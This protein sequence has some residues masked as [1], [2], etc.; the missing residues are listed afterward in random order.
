[1]YLGSAWFEEWPGD[2]V[3]DAGTAWFGGPDISCAEF[4]FDGGDCASD[5]SGTPAVPPE[6][7]ADCIS[8]GEAGHYDCELE[9]FK[10]VHFGSTWLEEWPGDGVCDDGTGW[11]GGPDISCAEF[12]FDGGDCAVC[13][14]SDEGAADSTG[15]ACTDYIDD[16]DRCGL[17]DDEDFDSA[18]VCC[19]CG[20]GT[21]G[22]SDGSDAGEPSDTGAVGED[23]T[24]IVDDGDADADDGETGPVPG[25]ACETGGYVYDCAGVCIS[26]G[27]AETWPGDGMCDGESAF[28]GAHLDCEAFEFDG[29]DCGTGSGGDGD[30]GVPGASCGEDMV[31]DCDMT[32]VSEPAAL[33]SI[34]DGWCDAGGWWSSYDLYCSAFSFDGSDCMIP[35]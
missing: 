3:C 35:F 4:D 19:A 6:I 23:D 2:G 1:M 7:G 30:G 10:S 33:E 18:S 34:G 26:V 17:Y 12:D 14:D 31:Y 13:V 15:G 29:G 21:T 16:P 27:W 25:E 11:F 32:C 28:S 9:C 22:I 5:G 24:G 8:G 20:G